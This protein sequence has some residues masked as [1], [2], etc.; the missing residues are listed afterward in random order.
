MEQLFFMGVEIELSPTMFG[1]YI[2]ILM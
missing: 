1:W 2:K